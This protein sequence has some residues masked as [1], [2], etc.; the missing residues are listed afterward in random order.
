MSRSSM[1]RWWPF[2]PDSLGLLAAVLAVALPLSAT[3][4]AQA[5]DLAAGARLYA[6]HCAMCHG[7]TGRPGPDSPVA[8]A[9]DPPPA[10]LSDPLFN[11]RE[12]AP[13]WA[14]VISHGGHAMGLSAQMPA[15]GGVLTAAQVRDVVA[16]VKSLADTTGYP[17][18]ELNYFLALRTRKAFPEDEVVWKLR[19]TSRDGVDELRN[20]LEVEKRVGRRGQLIA[21]LVH[22]DDGRTSRAREVQLGYK[23]VL[24]WN[25]QRASIL[26]G[27]L[28]LAVPLEG[29]RSLALQPSLAWARAW[30]DRWILQGSARA[31]LPLDD[32][33]LGEVEVAAALHHRWTP[34]PRRVFP[35]VELVA[36]TPFLSGEG[37]RMQW[38]VLPQ[39][40]IGLT[41]GG[42]VALNIGIEAPLSDQDWDWRGHM[43]LLWDFADGSLFKGW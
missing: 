17:P 11:S 8:A 2:L 35:G 24:G 25:L 30:S 22:A 28:V 38:S 19:H 43:V 32:L 14:M 7:A 31:V 9:L 33:D 13:D 18:G 29:D 12:P 6:D 39:V 42:H 26:S 41:R 37:D 21:E 16:Y 27:S 36:R 5:A 3:V 15:Q 10:D 20:V 1:P 23:H 40:R 4:P 34:W